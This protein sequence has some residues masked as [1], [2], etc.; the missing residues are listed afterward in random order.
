[1]QPASSTSICV[2]MV[3]A[4]FSADV[5]LYG[6]VSVNYR[7]SLEAADISFCMEM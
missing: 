6:P 3:M 1:M 4:D 2:Y 7:Q 5:L